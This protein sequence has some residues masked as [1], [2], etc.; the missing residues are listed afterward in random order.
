MSAFKHA[1]HYAIANAPYELFDNPGKV[2]IVVGDGEY[3]LYAADGEFLDLCVI[4]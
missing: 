4:D 3:A 1:A 2:V